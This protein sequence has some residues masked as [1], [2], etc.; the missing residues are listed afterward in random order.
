[1]R[2]L[3]IF[4]NMATC[5]HETRIA[6]NQYYASASKSFHKNDRPYCSEQFSIPY[7]TYPFLKILENKQKFN[8]NR[9]RRVSKLQTRKKNSSTGYMVVRETSVSRRHDRDRL[10]ALLKPVG[11]SQHYRIEVFKGEYTLVLVRV[12]SFLL[13]HREIFSESC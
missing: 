2:F 8:R 9:H 5:R 3:S 12:K 11:P 1:M 10:M 4:L 13:T 6:I 7:V